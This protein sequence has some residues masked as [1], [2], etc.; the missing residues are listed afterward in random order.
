[1]IHLNSSIKTNNRIKY[2]L[3]RDN[4][5]YI[6]NIVFGKIVK[7][8]R[9]LSKKYKLI[10]NTNFYNESKKCLL[11]NLNKIHTLRKENFRMLHKQR[12]QD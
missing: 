12:N 1:M 7:S 5:I 11:E 8:N 4:K 3:Q 2:Y 6:K 10:M 9:L